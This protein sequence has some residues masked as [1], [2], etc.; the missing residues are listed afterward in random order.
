MSA[1]AARE[2]HPGNPPA[3]SLASFQ[4][5]TF[6]TLSG[7]DATP[8]AR[9]VSAGLATLIVLNVTAAVVETVESIHADYRRAFDWFEWCSVAVFSIEYLLRLWA[10]PADPRYSH[11]FFGRVRFALSPLMLIDLV[12][13]LPT[14]IIGFVDVDLRTLRAIRLI[15]LLRVLKI[16]RYSETLQLLGRVF[17]ARRSELFVTLIAAIILLVVSATLMYYTERDAQP[18]LFSSIPAAM[19]WSIETLT[20]IGYGDIVPATTLGRILN[21]FIAFL[22]VGLF[23]LPAGILGSAFVEEVQRRGKPARCPKCGYSHEPHDG[24]NDRSPEG[25]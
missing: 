8:A 6:R 9:A 23:A 5:R 17:V 4:R 15:R 7:A 25:R 3:S 20:T 22:G 21:S 18:E 19:W 12:A 2:F 16:A 1:D 10:C 14:F 11:P 24:S 13:I